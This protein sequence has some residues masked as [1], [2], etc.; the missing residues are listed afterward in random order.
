M[1]NIRR[2]EPIGVLINL[3]FHINYLSEFS[4]Y[5]V[6]HFCSKQF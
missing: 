3:G 4:A 1:G 5:R 6:D 2:L